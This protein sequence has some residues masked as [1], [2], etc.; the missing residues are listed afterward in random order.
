M[1][2][3]TGEA[4]VT[5][6]IAVKSIFEPKIAQSFVLRIRLL[7]QDIRMKGKNCEV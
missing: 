6:E 3:F 4:I 7:G 2:I 5:F 1:P